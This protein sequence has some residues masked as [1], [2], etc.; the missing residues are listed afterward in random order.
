MRRYHVGATNVRNGGVA[1]LFLTNCW[2]VRP[3]TESQCV[4][5]QLTVFREIA[6][7]A[8]ARSPRV[9]VRTLRI[10]IR[11]T[12]VPNERCLTALLTPAGDRDARCRIV[13]SETSGLDVRL[14]IDGRTVGLTHRPD[15]HHVEPRCSTLARIW[16]ASHTELPAS[17]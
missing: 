7:R 12:A 10:M 8:L 6:T 9:P 3:R 5:S 14:E 16:A 2:T 1:H 15:W 17:R 11:M 13:V 4:V